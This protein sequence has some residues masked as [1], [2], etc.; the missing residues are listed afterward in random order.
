MHKRRKTVPAA[1]ITDALVTH[2]L[3]QGLGSISRRLEFLGEM[4]QIK[5]D[6]AAEPFAAEP[7]VEPAPVPPVPAALEAPE[8][9]RRGGCCFAQC[10]PF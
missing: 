9:V 7:A 10:V 5:K 2:W 4:T 3:M 1:E 6:V 8:R